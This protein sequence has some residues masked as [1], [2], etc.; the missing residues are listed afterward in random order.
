MN[1]SLIKFLAYGSINI[2]SWPLLGQKLGLIV[3]SSLNKKL[4]ID[5]KI[6]VSMI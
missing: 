2:C 1:Y 3:L 5:T 6:S 4:R